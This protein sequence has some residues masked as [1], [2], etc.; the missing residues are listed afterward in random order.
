MLLE[1]LQVAGEQERRRDG[2]R[3]PGLLIRDARERKGWS[4]RYLAALL[5][6]PAVDLGEYERNV[7]PVPPARWTELRRV[8]SGLPEEMPPETATP[9]SSPSVDVALHPAGQCTCGSE[10]RC[11]W[12]EMDRRRTLREARRP[13]P[14]TCTPDSVCAACYQRGYN[15]ANPEEKAAERASKREAQRAKRTRKARRGW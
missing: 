10:G 8:L 12:C 3:G 11:A 9:R 7:E 2:Q 6:M 13:G 14:C 5:T 15:D 1:E 4:L